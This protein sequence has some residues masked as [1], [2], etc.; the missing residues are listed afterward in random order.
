MNL[1]NKRP[2]TA[3]GMKATIRLRQSCRSTR[4]NRARYSQSTASIAPVWIA[5]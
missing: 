5:R 1:P 3:A 4:K 2:R